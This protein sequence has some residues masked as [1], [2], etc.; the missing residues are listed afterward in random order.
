LECRIVLRRPIMGFEIQDQRHQGFGDKAAAKDAEPPV[1]VRT[2][3]QG[4][5][6][7]GVHVSLKNAPA[8]ASRSPLRGGTARSA[9]G[10]GGPSEPDDA[11]PHPTPSGPPSPQGEG[12]ER[13]IRRRG[14][15]G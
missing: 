14:R 12:E 5:F 9:K 8:P 2:I 10:G 15:F 11:I 1:V 3:A 6:S 4:I 7:G 13:L